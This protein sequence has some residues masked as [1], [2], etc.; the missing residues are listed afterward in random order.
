MGFFLISCD[1]QEI[2]VFLYAD[3][4]AFAPATVLS[5]SSLI[6]LHFFIS[7][8]LC[9][10]SPGWDAFSRR[11]AEREHSLLIW[12]RPCRWGGDLNE[13]LTWGILERGRHITSD[14]L[15][16]C[17]HPSDILPPDSFP[18]TRMHTQDKETAMKI[19]LLVF[20]PLPH[21]HHTALDWIIQPV[22][23]LLNCFQ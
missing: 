15:L 12:G 16:P 13:D 10:V 22:S 18:R 6:R 4:L 5:F 2:S 20:P 8:S 19:P 17:L 7:S 3:S 14:S 21:V 1:I 11:R 9:L 23:S